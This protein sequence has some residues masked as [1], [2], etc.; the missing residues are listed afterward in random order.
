MLLSQKR[1][2]DKNLQIAP[3]NEKNMREYILN[4]FDKF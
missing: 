3:S 2:F 1:S 4:K